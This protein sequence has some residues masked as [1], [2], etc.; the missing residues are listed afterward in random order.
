MAGNPG[1]SATIGPAGKKRISLGTHPEI[2]LRQARLSRDEARALLS[3]GVNPRVHRKQQ[4]LAVRRADE[5]TFSIVFTHWM[6]RR[7]L[8]IKTGKGSTHAKMV[9]VFEKD[10]LP[11]LGKQAI[12]E[13]KRPD[14][15]EIVAR[16]ER[17]QVTGHAALFRPIVRAGR[18][19]RPRPAQ[20][21]RPGQRRIEAIRG[22]ASAPARS[23]R[24]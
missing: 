16:I 10:I 19:D 22:R 6:E 20:D 21:R 17:R 13:I 8:E 3:Q 14:L 9:R 2:S 7:K 4:K 24:H 23:T 1:I 11:F 18:Q 12:H 15:I 5:N